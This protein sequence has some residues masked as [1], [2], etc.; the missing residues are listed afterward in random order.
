VNRPIAFLADAVARH[1]RPLD[2]VHVEIPFSQAELA[3]HYRCSAGTVAYYLHHAGEVVVSRRRK[4]LIVDCRA[5]EAAAVRPGGRGGDCRAHPV[6]DHH[7]RVVP[8]HSPTPTPSQEGPA[9]NGDQVVEIIA[10]LAS[11]LTEMSRQL[12]DAGQKLLAVVAAAQPADSATKPESDP[13]PEP[14]NPADLAD[15]FS[16]VSRKEEELPSY[17]SR[18]SREIREDHQVR[19]PVTGGGDPLP[20]QRVDEL[21]EPLRAL[22][23]RTGRP[24]T[25][26]DNGRAVLAQL[27]E[28]QLRQGVIQAQREATDPNVRRPVGVLVHRALTGHSEFFAAP[29]PPQPRQSAM[30]DEAPHSVE[31][32]PEDA[33][34]A[35]AVAALEAQE[36]QGHELAVL[37][38]EVTAWL[39][40]NRAALIAWRNA[41]TA[42]AR[43]IQRQRAWRRLQQRGR[44]QAVGMAEAM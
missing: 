42:E 38:E 43:R 21:V 34:A 40:G 31:E 3:R 14:A 18:T 30:A 9:L 5:L 33:E 27:S 23:R 10:T 12:A 13:R 37:D 25:L 7:L 36:G 28:E 20:Y 22:A 26:D 44:D 39:S 4:R 6:G 17:Q 24:D 19:S 29:P 2:D 11:C 1:G 15:G 16:F 41:N 32:P 35:A 8:D